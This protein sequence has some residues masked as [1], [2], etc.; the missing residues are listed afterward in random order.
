MANEIVEIGSDYRINHPTF[1][2]V[3]NTTFKKDVIIA[4]EE[5]DNFPT[6]M[7]Q[8]ENHGWLPVFYHC[9]KH[10]YDENMR[11]LQE[12]E[13]LKGG[14]LAFEVGDEVKILI[15]KGNPKYVVG[16]IKQHSP[17][18]MCKDIFRITLDSEKYFIASTQK[19]LEGGV[20]YYGD[21]PYCEHKAV[22]CCTYVLHHE[23][24]PPTVVS[25][26]TLY[27]QND[28]LRLGP[29]L[30]YFRRYTNVNHLYPVGSMW[31]LWSTI[32]IFSYGVWTQKKEDNLWAQ[33]ERKRCLGP[34]KDMVFLDEVY[35]ECKATIYRGKCHPDAPDQCGWDIDGRLAQIYGQSEKK[36]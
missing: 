25:N 17:Y 15:E 22:T 12:N 26:Y 19:V 8:T 13:S 16:H 33:A 35:N 9:K 24:G 34:E 10:C 5:E 29:M 2:D 3:Y 20:D 23:S 21:T 14:I 18:S 32:G 6:G 31:N 4:I 11:F 28:F 1:K 27:Y 36:E 30:Y 7:C